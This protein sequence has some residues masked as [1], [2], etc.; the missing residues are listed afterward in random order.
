MSSKVLEAIKTPEGQARVNEALA[1]MCG[2]PREKGALRQIQQMWPPRF[3]AGLLPDGS[4]DEEAVDWAL[5]GKLWRAIEAADARLV[6]LRH[7]ILW[8]AEARFPPVDCVA[9]ELVEGRYWHPVVALALVAEG[10]GLLWKGDA[11]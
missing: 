1:V 4:C 2:I 10:L 8:Q 3:L 9:G 5:L 11:Q 7:V 6:Q